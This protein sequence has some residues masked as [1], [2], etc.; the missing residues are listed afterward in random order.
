MSNEPPVFSLRDAHQYL[1]CVRLAECVHRS[2]R[3]I[4]DE[5]QAVAGVPAA[6]GSSGGQQQ[7]AQTSTPPTSTTPYTAA[8]SS[9]PP[10]LPGSMATGPAPSSFPTPY[11]HQQTPPYQALQP[12]S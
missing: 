7:P 12:P 5:P 6:P 8:M 4:V 1:T 11:G 3:K 2:F 9:I 10:H